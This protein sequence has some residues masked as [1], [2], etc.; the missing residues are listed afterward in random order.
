ML[1]MY[2]I[3]KEW[4]LSVGLSLLFITLQLESCSKFLAVFAAFA[5]SPCA[6]EKTRF[7]PMCNLRDKCCWTILTRASQVLPL[8]ILDLEIFYQNPLRTSR[9]D[10]W[11]H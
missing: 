8:Q 5:D 11:D 6:A 9:D 3:L 7:S 10:P 1:V 4:R 2:G